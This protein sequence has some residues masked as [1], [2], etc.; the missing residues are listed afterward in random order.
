[1]ANKVAGELYESI[2][3]QLFE[4]GR[5]LR[6]PNGYPFNPEML[7]KYLQNGIEGRFI[8]SEPKSFLTKPFFPAEFIGEGW[9]VEEQDERSLTFTEIELAAPRFETCLK[10]G[11][12]SITGEEKLI[13]LKQS[14][15]IILGGNAFLG[16]WLDYQVNKENSALECLWRNYKISYL[17]FFGTV[18]C[19][20]DGCRIVI[21]LYL[22]NDG[23]WSWNYNL[24]K[25]G[26]WNAR[27]PSAVLAS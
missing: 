1:M 5:Q 18:V 19:H 6:Q 27:R 15:K 14:K 17:D 3:G 4:I 8:F 22:N 2:T 24:L 9:T 20:T 25:W 13:R 26:D 12:T 7:K 23:K 10:D 11:E 16:L 21:Y